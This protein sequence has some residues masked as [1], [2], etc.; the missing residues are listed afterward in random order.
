MRGKRSKIPDRHNVL[1]T[2][3]W[4]F[5]KALILVV[6]MIADMTM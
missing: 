5:G 4:H 3:S 1:R 6:M 2:I